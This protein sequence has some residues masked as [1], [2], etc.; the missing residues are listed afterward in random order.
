MIDN[1]DE[2]LNSIYYKRTISK[3]VDIKMG[4][5]CYCHAK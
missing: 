1:G 4:K 5:I 3:G 2:Q